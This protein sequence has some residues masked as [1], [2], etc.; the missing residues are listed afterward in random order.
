MLMREFDEKL[1]VTRDL[2]S[3]LTDARDPDRIQ[4]SLSQML[5]ITKYAMAIDSAH[6][7]AAAGRGDDAVF[8]IATSDQR[9][10]SMLDDDEAVAS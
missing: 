6:A 4:H 7:S 5:R 1:Y 3:K 10:L 2:A 8:K 9:G